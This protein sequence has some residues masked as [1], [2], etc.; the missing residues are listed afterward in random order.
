[1]AVDL[2]QKQLAYALDHEK[3]EPLGIE[4]HRLSAAEVHA[5]WPQGHFA[6]VTACMS[7]HDMASIPSVLASAFALLP[8][9]GRL[10]FSIPHPGTDTPYRQW[11]RDE[12]GNQ[13]ALKIDRYFDSGPAVCHWRMARL[14]Y[15]WDT[16]YWRH[17]LSEWSGM[18]AGA[19]FLIRRLHE[20][21]PT[22][23]QVRENPNIEDAYRLPGFLIFDAIK[24][25]GAVT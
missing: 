18:I 19:G 5:H 12:A 9:G 17:T 6:L 13:A 23:D 24:L 7:L 14:R 20:P 3:R 8:E 2:A 11:E 22:P 10:V 25:T 15:H 1:V 21:R 16:P 4:Y